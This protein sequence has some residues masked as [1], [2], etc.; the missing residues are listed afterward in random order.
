M[1]T[2]ESSLSKR[3]Q[4]LLSEALKAGYVRVITL[5]CIILGLPGVGKTLLKN[6]LLSK[7]P[8]PPAFRSSTPCAEAPIRIEVRTVSGTR[9]RNEQGKWKEVDD[10]GML[11]VV[12]TMILS[13]QTK[14][15][16]PNG[17]SGAQGTS[18]QKPR[19][20]DNIIIPECQQLCVVKGRHTQVALSRM[21]RFEYVK[22]G[23]SIPE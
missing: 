18:K 22:G 14:P 21:R 8:V 20:N 2:P 3:S 13:D 6:L 23:G 15:L 16:G 17:S 11:D 5:V 19:K 4:R 7:P 10:N 1:I 9:V 12:A